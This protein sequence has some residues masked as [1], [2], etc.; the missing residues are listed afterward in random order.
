[1]HEERDHRPVR[2]ALVRVYEAAAAKEVG[3]RFLVE[4]LWPRGVKKDALKMEAWTREAAPSTALRQWFGHEPARWAEFQRRYWAE[5]DANPEGWRQL[6]DAVRAGPVVFLFSSRNTEH[7][8][9]VALRSYLLAHLK[10]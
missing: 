3:P 8:N 6:R 10:K 4:R 5:L 7:N 2:I 9:A 1:M